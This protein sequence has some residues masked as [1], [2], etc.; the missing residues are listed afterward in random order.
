MV[1]SLQSADCL[2]VCK[3]NV[4]EEDAPNNVHYRLSQEMNLKVNIFINPLKTRER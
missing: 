3:I 2:F 4:K 1:Q